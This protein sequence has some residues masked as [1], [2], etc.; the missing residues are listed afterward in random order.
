[1]QQILS[2]AGFRATELLVFG[3]GYVE[4]EEV[5]KAGGTAVGVATAEPDCLVIDDWKRNRL[6]KVGADF[7]VPNYLNTNEIDRIVLGAAECAES[8]VETTVSP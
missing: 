5:K 1:V 4:V 2:Q 3:D 8:V 7:I 6:V